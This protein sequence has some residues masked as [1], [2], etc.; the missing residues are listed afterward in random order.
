LQDEHNLKTTNLLDGDLKEMITSWM[1][2]LSVIPANP[3]R[4]MEVRFLTQSAVEILIN[5]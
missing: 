3:Q 5:P 2:P 4:E 1:T